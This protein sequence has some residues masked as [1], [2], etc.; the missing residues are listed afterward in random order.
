MT[1]DVRT[2]SEIPKRCRICREDFSP[3]SREVY[4]VQATYLCKP[5][6]HDLAVSYYETFPDESGGVDLYGIG[7]HQGEC[8]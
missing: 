7:L 4:L 3:D 8:D 1:L 2:S 6:W 5:C